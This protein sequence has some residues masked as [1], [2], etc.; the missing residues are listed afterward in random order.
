MKQAVTCKSK[1]WDNIKLL[2]QVT[3]TTEAKFALWERVESDEIGRDK[4]KC[5]SVCGGMCVC[6][7]ERVR[8]A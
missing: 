8:E 7:K 4:E 1:Y 2:S 3:M 6:E 5:E